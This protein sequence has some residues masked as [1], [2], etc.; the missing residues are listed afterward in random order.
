MPPCVFFSRNATDSGE[1]TQLVLKEHAV[2]E[3]MSIYRDSSYLQYLVLQGVNQN[4]LQDIGGMRDLVFSL[5]ALV[6][7][8][9]DACSEAQKPSGVVPNYRFLAQ[10]LSDC[11]G[12]LPSTVEESAVQTLSPSVVDVLAFE[13]RLLSAMTMD[14]IR[15]R[16]QREFFDLNQPVRARRHASG[17]SDIW[18]VSPPQ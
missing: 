6:E 2:A 18:R 3:R 5:L 14:T 12:G 4:V 8:G 10:A 15:K 16:A 7:L 9:G 1:R 11:H 17:S 13:Q